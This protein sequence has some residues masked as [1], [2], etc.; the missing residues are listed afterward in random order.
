MKRQL[1]TIMFVTTMLFFAAVFPFSSALGQDIAP[2]IE[3]GNAL[4]AQRADLEKCKESIGFYKKALEVDPNNYEANWRAC[5]SI[6]YMGHA[7]PTELTDIKEKYGK[8]AMPYGE[9]AFQINPDKVEGHYYYVYALSSYA[10]GCGVFAAISEGLGDKM[11][12]QYPLAIKIDKTYDRMGIMR[13]VGEYYC[14][15]PWPKRDLEKSIKYLTE[16][17][18]YAPENVKGHLLLA[19]SYEKDGEEDLAIK[20]A[21]LAIS[22]QPNYADEPEADIWKKEAK[23]LLKEMK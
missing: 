6:A 14:V 20:E 4:Y 15:L 22:V 2:L 3:K 13:L 9:K 10:M 11:E 19:K 12:T 8:M 7:V 23:A 5:R 21:E 17:V 1:L 18:A 16:G